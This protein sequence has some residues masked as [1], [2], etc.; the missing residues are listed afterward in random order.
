MKG[1]DLEAFKQSEAAKR[2]ENAHLV[3]PPKK[4]SKRPKYN[5]E[6]V[7]YDGMVFDS[8]KEYQRYRHLLLLVKA[9]EITLP[10]RQV[11]FVLIPAQDGERKMSYFA[12]FV[13]QIQ[14]TGLT[15]VEDVKSEATK[16]L[17]TY[18]AKRKL[19]KKEYGISIKEV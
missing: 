16:K 7:E 19:M 2:P 1:W 8:K 18:I 17:S 6:K 10:R 9:G 13:Y 5:N 4:A 14:A 11:E 15:V 12:D 3:E